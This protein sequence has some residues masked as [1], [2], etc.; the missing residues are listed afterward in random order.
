MGR[1]VRGGDFL[2][3]QP[4]WQRLALAGVGIK[5]HRIFPS[6]YNSLYL[7]FWR[8]ES[9]ALKGNFSDIAVR[10]SPPNAKTFL[11]K[12]DFSGNQLYSDEYPCQSKR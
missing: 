4:P 2:I 1:G 11:K 7:A 6:L 3:F 10:Y 12:M 5:W 8:Y 9:V